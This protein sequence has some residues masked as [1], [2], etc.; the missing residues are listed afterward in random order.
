MKTW[1]IAYKFIFVYFQVGMLYSAF[2]PRLGD[3]RW[4]FV[5]GTIYTTSVRIR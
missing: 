1:L 4:P 3:M 2:F 5:G